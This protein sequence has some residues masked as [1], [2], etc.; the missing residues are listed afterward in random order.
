[1]VNCGRRRGL[2]G[3]F[4]GAASEVWPDGGM[5]GVCGCGFSPG[6]LRRRLTSMRLAVLTHRGYGE[7]SCLCP[8]AAARRGRGLDFGR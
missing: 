8:A 4:A 2:T 3:G 5:A 7:G 6:R 1:M